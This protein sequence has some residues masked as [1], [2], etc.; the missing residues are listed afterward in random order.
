MVFNRKAF[1]KYFFSNCLALL[2][3]KKTVCDLDFYNFQT[4]QEKM[5]NVFLVGAL[6][7]LSKGQERLGK[8]I[9]KKKFETSR[10]GLNSQYH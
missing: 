2:F 10:K 1:A 7:E 5:E 3:V 4:E 9:I 6:E 8:K